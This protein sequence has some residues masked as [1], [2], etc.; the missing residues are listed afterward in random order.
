[1]GRV[2]LVTD[3]STCLPPALA[4][5][6]GIRVL[7]ISIYLPEE[8]AST[9]PG[10]LADWS[11]SAAAEEEELSGASRPFVTEYLAA[12]EGS[13]SDAAVLVTPAIE[14][15]DMFR[16]ASL[17]A[18]LADRRAVA[19]DAR[20][21]AAGQALVVL[22]GAEVAR[23]DGDLDAVVAAVEEAARRVELVASLE[24]L[25]PIRRSGPV[26][27]DVL[28]PGAPDGARS[29]F[30]MHDGVVE[31]LGTAEDAEA[32]LQEIR[33]AYRRGAPGGTERSTVFHADSPELA[34]RLEEL[35]GG[36]DFVSGFSL[37]MQ[38]HTG[39]GVVGAAWLPKV[40]VR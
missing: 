3:S 7:P 37:A 4:E 23:R 25:A 18:G 19:V 30:R 10:V 28:G 2:A 9:G 35:L 8:R 1:V 38:V 20:T 29:V 27:E 40:G 13:G 15:A 24:T 11:I 32:S 16:N 31:P 5:E 17:A 26:P 39:R 33:R 36:V 12:V 21:A 34:R 22:A 14:F 6:L